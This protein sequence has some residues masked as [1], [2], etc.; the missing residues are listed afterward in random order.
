MDS[1]RKNEAHS[2]SE[3][4]R[5]EAWTPPTVTATTDLLHRAA[6]RHHR[7]GAEALLDTLVACGVDTIFGYPGGAALPLYDA[8]HGEPRAAPRAGAPRAGG[9]ACGRGLCAQHRPRGRGAGHLGAGR[10]QHHHRPARRHERLGARAVHQRAGGHRR[11]RHQGLP[12]ERRAGHVAPG[13]QVEPP[14]ARAPTTWPRGARALE[15]ASTG[16]PGPV[17]LDVPKD[18]Q[19]AHPAWAPSCPRSLRRA[20][21]TLRTQ[22]RACRPGQPAARRRP[23][24][25]RAPAGALRRR[26]P[27][28]LRARGVR[29]LHASWCACWTRRPRSR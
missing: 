27:G 3:A 26:R 23:A 29:R 2:A 14:A 18:V 12:G 8:L 7:N 4:G 10:G 25:D 5:I 6:R 9:G 28:Q 15:I 1:P 20:R 13:D 17:L 22:A 24:V 19:L 16:R 11:H 21:R